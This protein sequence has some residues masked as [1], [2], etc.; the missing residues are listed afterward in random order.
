MHGCYTAHGFGGYL[1]H[2]RRYQGHAAGARPQ[3]FALILL[4]FGISC[5]AGEI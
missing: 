3:A 2:W 1:R 5:E 4:T